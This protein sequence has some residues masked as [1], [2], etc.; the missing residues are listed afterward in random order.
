MRM[1]W[2][3][4]ATIVSHSMWLRSSYP[5]QTFSRVCFVEHD[6]CWLGARSEIHLLM[7]PGCCWSISR[8]RL[9][10]IAGQAYSKVSAN[11]SIASWRDTHSGPLDALQQP[12]AWRQLLPFFLAIHE[13]HL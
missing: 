4:G 5:P 2:V 11:C 13:N 7:I 3:I 10:F 1:I 9:A 8:V 12:Q 6:D